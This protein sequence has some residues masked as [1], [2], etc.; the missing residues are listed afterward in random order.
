MSRM[1]ACAVL[2]AAF[3]PALASADACKLSAQRDFD[4]DAAG[5]KTLKLELGASDAHIIGVAGLTKVEVRGRACADDQAQLDRMQVTQARTGDVLD[6][7]AKLESSAI[8]IGFGHSGTIGLKLDVRVPASLALRVNAAAGDV[9]VRGVA[10]LEFD[11]VAGDLKVND[12]AGAVVL[13]LA[14]GDVEGGNLGSLEVKRSA[15]GDIKLHDVKGD[16]HLAGVG[17]GDVSLSKVDGSVEIGN[18]G[19]GDV[20][21]SQVALDVHVTSLGIGDLE[22][23]DVGGDLVVRSQ[24]LGDINHR[25]VRGKVEVPGGNEE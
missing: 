24:G 22:V 7:A 4:V 2:I 20:H 8:N 23:E 12:V 18:I 6:V 5:L 10:S 16:A 3:T 21:V 13:S 19:A 1:F 14:A 25:N 17:A 15:A 11:S 9:D